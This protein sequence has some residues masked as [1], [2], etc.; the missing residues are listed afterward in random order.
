VLLFVGA[1]TGFLQLYG[2][3][4]LLFVYVA[5]VG[6]LFPNITAMAMAPQGARAGSASAMIGVLQFS[7]AATSAS[8]IGVANSGDAMPVAALIGICGVSAAVLYW[9]MVH[10]SRAERRS[11]AAAL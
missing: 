8:L 10:G 2:V 7:L 4:T 6:C 1:W 3:A 9:A 11:R 5:S